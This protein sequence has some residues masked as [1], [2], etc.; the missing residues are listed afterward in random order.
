[1]LSVNQENH[2]GENVLRIHIARGKSS[3]MSKGFALAVL[4]FLVFLWAIGL[5]AIS[6][7]WAYSWMRPL[8]GAPTLVGEWYGE[9]VFPSGRKQWIA[10]DIDSDTRRCR[11][12]CLSI[13]ASGRVCDSQGLRR[14]EGR[15]APD[16]WSG[17]RFDLSL[18][19]PD[20]SLPG[21]DIIR[22]RAERED[23]MLR[24]TTEFEPIHTTPDGAA[25]AS[26]TIKRGAAPARTDVGTDEMFIVDLLLR[27]SGAE[28]FQ[29]AC[30][31]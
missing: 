24:T 17:T 20:I 15:T 5:Q 4:L 8:T 10:L 11:S 21:F 25:I 30:P 13:V 1:M 29:E 27:R 22:I 28:D 12:R 6:Y 9:T 23:E 19:S 14:F 7:P 2:G 16:N 18:T 26:A 3:R 31:R